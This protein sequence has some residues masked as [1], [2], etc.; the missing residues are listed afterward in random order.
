MCFYISISFPSKLVST[1]K[2]VFKT[3]QSFSDKTALSSLQIKIAK[4]SV[5][6]S[7]LS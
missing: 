4:L 3:L 1:H 7:E 5:Y 2:I 6:V